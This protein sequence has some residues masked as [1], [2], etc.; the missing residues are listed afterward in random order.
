MM[1]TKKK[2]HRTDSVTRSGYLFTQCLTEVD[3][4]VIAA[5]GKIDR[6][7]ESSHVPSTCRNLP[8]PS[9]CGTR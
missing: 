5:L 6:S 9:D 4:V 8:S 7:W 2:R 3:G 1:L